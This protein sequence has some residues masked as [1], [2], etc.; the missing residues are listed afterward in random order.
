MWPKW[1]M[2]YAMAQASTFLWYRNVNVGNVMQWAWQQRYMEAADQNTIQGL[3]G[4]VLFGQQPQTF[5]CDHRRIAHLKPKHNTA[6]R[7]F[8]NKASFTKSITAGP[9]V[10]WHKTTIWY[11]VIPNTRFLVEPIL[12]RL[13][14]TRFV[15]WLC[16]NL[17]S[18]LNEV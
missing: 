9:L 7:H 8:W 4:M 12:S 5:N 3:Q 15:R 2:V 16:L 11:G 14:K 10:L 6:K 13:R 1:Y 17:R 18:T